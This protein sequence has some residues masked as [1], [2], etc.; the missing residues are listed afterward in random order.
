M[1]IPNTYCLLSMSM[2]RV[3]AS[4]KGDILK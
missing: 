4:A 1:N 3:R 2:V